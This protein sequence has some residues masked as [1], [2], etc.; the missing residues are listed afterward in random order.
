M[1]PEKIGR[2]EIKAE[3]GRGGMATVYQAY[4]PRFEREVA[5]KVLPR[6][7]L[8]DPQFRTRFE[9]EAKT[10]ALLEHPAI[11]PVYDYGEDDGQPYFVMRY[12]TGGSL[13]DRLKAGTLSLQEAARIFQRLA[14]PLD[15]AHSKGVV[16]RDLKPGNI[17]FDQYNEPYISDFGIAKLAQASG[18]VTGSAVI[19][20]PAYISPEQAQGEKIDGRADIYAMGVILYEL[21]TGAKPYEGDTPMS[22]VVKHITDPVPHILDVKP[23]LPSALEIVI[24]KA[25]AKKRD[26]RFNSVH[27]FATVLA[28]VARGETPDLSSVATSPRLASAKTVIARRPEADKT[29]LSK[30]AKQAQGPASAPPRKKSGAWI[31]IGITLGVLCVASVIGVVLFRDSIPF[32]AASTAT[33]PLPSTAT[34]DVVAPNPSASPERPTPPPGASTPTLQPSPTQR[35]QPAVGGG[36]LF[37][38]LSANDIW[39]VNTDASEPRRITTDGA[40]KHDLQWGP[41]GFSLFYISG[42]CV[43]TVNLVTGEGREI[44]CFLTADYFEAFE[45]SPDSSQV[46]ISLNRELYVVPFELETIGRARTRNQLVAMNGCFTYTV[47]G[48]KGVRWSS[49]GLS[50]AV[51]VVGVNAGRAVDMIRIFDIS[52]CNSVNPPYRDIFPGSFAMLGYND[53]P[54]ISSFDWDGETLFL[55]TSFYRNEGFGYLYV[56]NTESHLAEQLDPLGSGC[57]YRDPHWSPDGSRVIFAYQDL[58]QGAG[59]QTQLYFIPY[60][61]IGTGSTYHPLPLPDDFFTNPRE[62]PQPVMRP[63]RP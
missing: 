40:V 51:N 28:A 50:I 29:V 37:A 5:V 57:C 6:E 8:H 25:M 15:Q 23:D 17:L 61:T 20:T 11:V 33:I 16:H 54:I 49:D 55:L 46:A 19:G 45:I 7:M 10:I 32:L 48:T 42:K 60:G 1:I 31:G 43:H 4:D 34:T 14:S 53:R 39:V 59:S 9:R 13:S 41:E 62:Q 3:L 52:T 47:L 21:L 22:V 27:E 63:A 2:Y 44:T 58:R 38:F 56:Y 12:M 26:E 36:D 35:I 30:D 18:N 24:E